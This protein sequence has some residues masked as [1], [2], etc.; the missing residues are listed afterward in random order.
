[1]I[2]Q[3][4]SAEDEQF[5]F[6][7][8]RKRLDSNSCPNMP[9]LLANFYTELDRSVSTPIELSAM[10][11]LLGASEIIVDAASY[12]I[13]IALTDVT[14]AIGSGGAYD[15][16]LHRATAEL[17]SGVSACANDIGG[18]VERFFY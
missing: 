13:Q 2:E 9:V 8:T 11:S 6:E 12:N 1:A 3:L 17:H 4:E 15:T 16:A 18:V 7:V 5:E 14:L 10:P